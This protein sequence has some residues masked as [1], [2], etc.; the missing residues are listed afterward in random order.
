M[1]LVGTNKLFDFVKFKSQNCIFLG[2]I[3]GESKNKKMNFSE[4]G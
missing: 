2:G 1:S 4:N 3:E